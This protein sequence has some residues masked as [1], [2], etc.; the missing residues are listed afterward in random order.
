[1][2]LPCMELHVTNEALEEIAALALA[3]NTDARGL[4]AISE[5]VCTGREGG[6]A[7]RKKRKHLHYIPIRI[8]GHTHPSLHSSLPPSF[9]PSSLGAH[10]SHVRHP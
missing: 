3:K 8:F 1:V 4:R 5:R 9:P 10:A 7:G 2:L 6:K